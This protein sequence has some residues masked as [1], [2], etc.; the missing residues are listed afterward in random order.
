MRRASL[1]G[2]IL[3][4]IVDTEHAAHADFKGPLA[5]VR[6]ESDLQFRRVLAHVVALPYGAV[7]SR[8]DIEAVLARTE[9]T[10]AEGATR[11]RARRAL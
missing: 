9:L 3:F 5:L 2:S 11:V 8:L 6:L 10:E 7:S 4:L 1:A